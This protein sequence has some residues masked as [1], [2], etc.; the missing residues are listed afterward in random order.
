MTEHFESMCYLIPGKEDPH[1]YIC[2]NSVII[3]PVLMPHI[4]FI[5][6]RFMEYVQRNT[7]YFWTIQK[8]TSTV[9]VN[10]WYLLA[11]EIHNGPILFR[12]GESIGNVIITEP[13]LWTS[14]K[15]QFKDIA[16]ALLLKVIKALEQTE[17]MLLQIPSYVELISNQTPLWNSSQLIQ[18]Q[19]Q[20]LHQQ[21]QQQQRRHQQQQQRKEQ[22]QY[23][24]PQQLQEQLLPTQQEKCWW[25][26]LSIQSPLST[27]LPL[28]IKLLTQQ[29]KEFFLID[30]MKRTD[31]INC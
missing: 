23:L 29:Q 30:F 12:F 25:Q 3:P 24:Q 2:N 20:Q 6:I 27:K 7:D 14:Y 5:L 16:P 31:N 26:K 1:N 17:N 8:N 13:H 15:K 11:H 4:G 9:Y 22:L 10:T 19:Q 18:L 21:Q 28:P